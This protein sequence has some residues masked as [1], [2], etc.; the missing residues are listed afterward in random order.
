MTAPAT[1]PSSIAS[2]T[3]TSPGVYTVAPTSVSLIGGGSAIPATFGTPVLAAN[4]SGTLTKNGLGTLTLTAANTYTG[5]TTSTPARSPSPAAPPLGSGNLTVAN[6]ATCAIANPNGA[7]AN[8][9]TGRP[10]RHRPRSIS[11]PESTKPC[12]S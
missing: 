9:A 10:Q 12:V 8:A 7:V 2:L 5:G 3:I 6:G 11:L 4:A 1:G